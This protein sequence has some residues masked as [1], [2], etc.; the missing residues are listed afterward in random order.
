MK[1]RRVDYYPDEYIVGVSRLG[2]EHQGLYWMVCSLIMSHG[3]PIPNDPKWLG[4]LGGTG[5]ARC[6][7]LI[8]ELVSCG[9]LTENQGKI[10]QKR[11]EIEL[12]NAQKR[13][14]TATENGKNGGRPSR[15]NNALTEPGG[16]SGEK[17]TTNYQPST[18]NQQEESPNGDFVAQPPTAEATAPK[19]LTRRERYPTAGKLPKSGKGRLYPPEFE[20][21]WQEYPTRKEDTKPGC[22]AHWQRA[23]VSDRVD[24]DE[25]TA[26][27]RRYAAENAREEYRVGFLRWCREGLWLRTPPPT[28]VTPLKPRRPQSSEMRELCYGE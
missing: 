4:K 22:Y 5:A 13:I 19:S 27:A 18:T 2:F 6:R 14:E 10:G 17:L 9:K 21:A 28:N 25:I 16:F 11:A 26:A 12:K 20:A 1:V 7:K 24:P 3:G 23:V 8:A 15:K